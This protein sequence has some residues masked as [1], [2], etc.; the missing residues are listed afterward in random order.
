MMEALLALRL[1]VVKMGRLIAP[2][3]EPKGK[4]AL[5]MHEREQEREIAELAQA[6]PSIARQ[7]FDTLLRVKSNLGTLHTH[8]VKVADVLKWLPEMSIRKANDVLQTAIRDGVCRLVIVQKTRN[9]SVKY[10][11]F[12]DSIEMSE[13]SVIQS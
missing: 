5:L 11:S 2:K 1:E 13:E 4:F 12:E 8:C 7:H 10:L 9:E 6:L 3:T